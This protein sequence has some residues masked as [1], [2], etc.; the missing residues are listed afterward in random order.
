[1]KL[2]ANPFGIS[3]RISELID[4][5]EEMEKAKLEGK[6]EVNLSTVKF[7]TP[8]STLPLAVYANSNKMKITIT[9]DPAVDGVNYLDTIGFHKGVTALPENKRY[10]P[11]TKLVPKEDDSVLGQ[12][13]QLILN[14][15]KIDKNILLYLTSELVNNVNEHARIDHYWLLAQ[16]YPNKNI[17]EI[18]MADSG[19]GYKKSYKGTKFEVPTDEEAIINALEG[20]SSKAELNGRG[21]GIPSVSKISVNGFDGKLIIMSG[22]ALVYYKKDE[23]KEIKIKSNWKGSLV[24][25]NFMPKDIQYHKYV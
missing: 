11:I 3:D 10:L 8:L 12:Y 4:N 15:M 21:N 1:M 9:E 2:E 23:R 24:S 14:Q 7:V 19:I 6:K 25:M 5:L 22:N 13:E 18:T 17:C 16:Y 20:K